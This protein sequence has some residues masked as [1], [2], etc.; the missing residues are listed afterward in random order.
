MK[1]IL[2]ILQKGLGFGLDDYQF[3]RMPLHPNMLR[4]RLGDY[5]WLYHK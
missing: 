3:L 4:K 1:D 5:E 2:V